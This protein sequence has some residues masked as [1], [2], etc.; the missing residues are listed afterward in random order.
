MAGGGDGGWMWWLWYGWVDAVVCGAENNWV[1]KERE[2]GERERKNKKK[3]IKNNKERIFK[4]NV[5][6]K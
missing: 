3:L 6:N 4:W 1:E 5:K 2:R